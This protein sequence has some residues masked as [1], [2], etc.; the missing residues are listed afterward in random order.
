M[1]CNSSQRP[2][3]LPIM[4]CQSG[5]QEPR[6]RGFYLPFYSIE[7]T[8]KH[9]KQMLHTHKLIEAKISMGARKEKKKQ[10]KKE[11]L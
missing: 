8:H 5:N 7:V 10:R 4:Q 3:T 6:T 1:K 11:K 2:N 9:G